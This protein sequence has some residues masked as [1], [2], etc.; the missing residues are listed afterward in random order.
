MLK[1]N[2]VNRIQYMEYNAQTTMHSWFDL[3]SIQTQGF[4]NCT[5]NI[6]LVVTGDVL[7]GVGE[8]V[9]LDLLVELLG[10]YVYP[11]LVV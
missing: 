4:D 8:D 11:D 5:N 6:V 3:L 10:L 2:A 7:P 1:Q 9:V